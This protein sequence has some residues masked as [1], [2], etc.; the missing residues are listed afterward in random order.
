LEVEM[1]AVEMATFQV[2]RRRRA[3]MTMPTTTRITKLSFAVFFA[4]LAIAFI[5]G[6]SLLMPT[7]TYEA[8]LEG[9]EN[10]CPAGGE[11]QG[12]QCVIGPQATGVLAHEFILHHP[13]NQ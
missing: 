12:G 11:L 13:F 6:L 7:V 8:E 5:T 4:A 10:A 1:M 3:R 9:R 2:R